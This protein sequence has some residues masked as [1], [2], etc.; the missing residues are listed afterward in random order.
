MKITFQGNYLSSKGE[1]LYMTFNYKNIGF[2]VNEK[3]NQ[4]SPQ[5]ST[6]DPAVTSMVS[7]KDQQKNPTMQIV[8]CAK[9]KKVLPNPCSNQLTP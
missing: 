3:S 4:M 2:A 6:A 5:V 1:N 8:D 7:G 9:I